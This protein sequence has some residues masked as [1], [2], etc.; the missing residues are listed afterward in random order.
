MRSLDPAQYSDRIFNFTCQEFIN[1]RILPFLRFS[2]VNSLE[3]IPVCDRSS[4]SLGYPDWGPARAI[5]DNKPCVPS[6]TAPFQLKEEYSLVYLTDSGIVR[7]L[8]HDYDRGLEVILDPSQMSYVYLKTL[9][10]F[11]AYSDFESISNSAADSVVISSISTAVPQVDL[12]LSGGHF[13][14]VNR[15]PAVNLGVVEA[16]I[17]L[18]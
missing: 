1:P 15:T 16:S 14:L 5:P 18:L 7:G 8:S 6:V 10:G 9:A 17:L 12:L 4:L 11:F 13:D 2:T 3:T